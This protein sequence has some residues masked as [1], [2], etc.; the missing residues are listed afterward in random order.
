LTVLA[1][2]TS[3]RSGG[4]ALAREGRI[5]ASLAVEAP[6]GLAAT[7]FPSIERLLADAGVALAVI[8]GFAALAGPGSFTGVRVGLAAAKALAEIGGKPVAAISNLEAIAFCG[9]GPRRA[10]V[11]PGRG[12]EVFGA[13]FDAEMRLLLSE[14]I[15]PAA[16]FVERA[17]AYEPEWL[18]AEEAAFERL[19]LPPEAPCR[20]AGSLAEAAALLA[21]R[22]F[23]RG[24]G[25]PPEAVEANYVERPTV[26]RAARDIP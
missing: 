8:D 18:A 22:R 16:A 3:A 10:A 7:L 23:A 5:L 24:E 20:V 12:D 15:E 9:E 11:A 13:V 26:E 25:Q 19:G 14:R 17:A 4:F 1:I 6:E 2:D 21:A